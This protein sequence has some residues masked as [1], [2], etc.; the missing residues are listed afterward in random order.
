LGEIERAEVNMAHGEG[1]WAPL[2]DCFL[3]DPLF[4]QL[5]A[6]ARLAGA[7]IRYQSYQN[8]VLGA[9][10]TTACGGWAYSPAQQ[11]LGGE[12]HLYEIDADG[13]PLD[14]PCPFTDYVSSK[15]LLHV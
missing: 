4:E 13:L 7:E 12:S 14:R 15:A 6:M 3:E 5:V 1:G 2:L 11:C 10:F 9:R 8:E